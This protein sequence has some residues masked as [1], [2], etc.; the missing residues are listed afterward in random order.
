MYAVKPETEYFIECTSSNEFKGY[1]L[2]EYGE[3]FFEKTRENSR[4]VVYKEDL[5]IFLD[6]FT[7]EEI[8][9]TI[10]EKGKIELKYR[11]MFDG[12]P[13]NVILRAVITKENDGEKL[14][15]GIV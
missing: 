13:R 2:A 7:K 9:T 12:K 10:K 8:M 1:G 15:V 11:L 4:N 6:H 14:I 5:E 3:N